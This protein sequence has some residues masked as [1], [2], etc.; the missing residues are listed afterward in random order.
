MG[1]IRKLS[2]GV[3]RRGLYASVDVCTLSATGH[4]MCT[5]HGSAREAVS[6]LLVGDCWP[7]LCV[8]GI[9]HTGG[10]LGSRLHGPD[11]R[12][13]VAARRVWIPGC[14]EANTSSP[15]CCYVR[16]SP[17]FLCR[18]RE[19]APAVCV[20]PS[21]LSRWRILHV[22]PD[23]MERRRVQYD[24]EATRPPAVLRW[25]LFGLGGLVRVVLGG[26]HGPILL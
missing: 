10:L 23:Y 26:T 2:D 1:G 19:L 17:V 3:K 18:G 15:E 8:A 11:F 6:R 5:V 12:L 14:V 9:D 13:S 16:R 25:R 22:V 24:A 4:S 20:R 21:R 7:L